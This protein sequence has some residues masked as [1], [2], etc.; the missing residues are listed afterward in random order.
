MY[1]STSPPRLWQFPLPRGTFQSKDE[2]EEKTK[3]THVNDK[4]EYEKLISSGKVL[5]SRGSGQRNGALGFWS[6]AALALR[7]ESCW[8]HLVGDAGCRQVLGALVR[9]VQDDRALC[10]GAAGEYTAGKHQHSVR[11]KSVTCH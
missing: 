1:L 5:I 11:A 2:D 10:G 9:Q 3:L 7:P 6:R 8:S 4:K